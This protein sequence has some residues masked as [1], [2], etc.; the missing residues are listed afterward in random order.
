MFELLVEQRTSMSSRL[1]SSFYRIQNTFIKQGFNHVIFFFYPKIPFDSGTI[2]VIVYPF[3]ET[4]EPCSTFYLDAYL[5][6]SEIILKAK[7]RTEVHTSLNALFT[8]LQSLLVLFSLLHCV[9]FTEGLLDTLKRVY[10]FLIREGDCG[11][12]ISELFN[13]LDDC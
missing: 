10:S 13:F 7:S 5:I 12:K 11:L 1:H 9:A 6:K 2:S 8:Q 4:T 3:T